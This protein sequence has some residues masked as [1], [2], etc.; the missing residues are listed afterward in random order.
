MSSISQG[1]IAQKAPDKNTNKSGGTRGQVLS[2]SQAELPDSSIA[3]GPTPTRE[4]SGAQ[5]E[6]SADSVGQSAHG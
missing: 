5:V 4:R 3:D 1:G 2:S 6:G